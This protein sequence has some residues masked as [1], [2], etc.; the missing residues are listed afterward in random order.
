MKA[1]PYEPKDFEQIQ[2]WGKEW[3]ANYSE[4]QFPQIGFIVDDVAAYFLYQTDS[5]VC[6]LENMVSNKKIHQEIKNQALTLIAEAILKK[7][8]EEEFTVAYATTNN[9]AIAK[10]AAEHG[11]KCQWGHLLLIKDLTDP[12]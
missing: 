3:G 2:A 4:D 5:S 6:F 7:A 9:V 10:R 8:K 11:A 12:S 1:R